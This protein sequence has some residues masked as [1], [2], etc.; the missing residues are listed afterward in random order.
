MLSLDLLDP[1]ILDGLGTEQ[2]ESGRASI[3]TGSAGVTPGALGIT[4]CA[5]LVLDGTPFSFG[6]IKF[7]FIAETCVFLMFFCLFGRTQKQKRHLWRLLRRLITAVSMPE[8]V[9]GKL[10]FFTVSKP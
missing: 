8:L 3:E 4:D 5:V 6:G 2:P 1:I 10:P 9:D 7:S